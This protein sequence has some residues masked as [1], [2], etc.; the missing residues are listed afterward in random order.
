MMLRLFFCKIT[1]ERTST[2]LEEKS[3]A[4]QQFGTAEQSGYR[5]VWKNEQEKREEQLSKDS[6]QEALDWCNTRA[7]QKPHHQA[8]AR[9]KQ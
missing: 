8:A 3:S 5:F 9:Q 2:S 1:F 4:V 6:C 7:T